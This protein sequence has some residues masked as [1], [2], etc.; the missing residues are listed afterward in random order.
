[1]FRNRIV[2]GLNNKK[3]VL[4]AIVVVIQDVKRR[5]PVDNVLKFASDRLK[6]DNEV[7]YQAVRRCGQASLIASASHRREILSFVRK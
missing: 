6:K 4:V 3:V 2:F 1:M 5:L 7:V